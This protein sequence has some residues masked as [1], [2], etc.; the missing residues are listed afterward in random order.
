MTT[1][2]N[3]SDRNMWCAYKPEHIDELQLISMSK[4]GVTLGIF[5]CSF[6]R[7]SFDVI[8]IP[9]IHTTS[10]K[11]ISAVNLTLLRWKYHN[12]K[13]PYDA[14]ILIRNQLINNAIYS[15]IKQFYCALSLVDLLWKPYTRGMVIC[16]EAIVF[17]HVLSK[18]LLYSRL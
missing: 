10:S 9:T 16:R 2:I 1:S 3:Q 18:I 4:H 6:K 13:A 7:C 14:E 12:R 11:S 8:L 17:T 5:W 15:T